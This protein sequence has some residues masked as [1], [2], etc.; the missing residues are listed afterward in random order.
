MIH[1][2]PYL[3][4][5]IDSG[6]TPEEICMILKSVTDSRMFVFAVNANVEFFGQVHPLDFRIVP[7]INY[8]N[9]FLPVLAGNM[10]EKEGGTTIGITL[11]MQ[12]VTRIFLAVWNSMACFYFLCG[13]LAVFTGDMEQISSILVPLGFIIFGQALPRCC[14]YGPAKKA[15]ERLRVLLC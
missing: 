5:Q 13:I 6:K 4:E 7:R 15:L 3:E 11:Q 10:T 14:F 1:L 9:S 8:R 2:L 12:M